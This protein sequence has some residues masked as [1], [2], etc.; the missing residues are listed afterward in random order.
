M[1][2]TAADISMHLGGMS[3]HRLSSLSPALGGLLLSN[4]L[5]LAIAIQGKIQLMDVL[6]SSHVLLAK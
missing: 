3:Q 1:Q 2:G 5:S 4:L 6:N